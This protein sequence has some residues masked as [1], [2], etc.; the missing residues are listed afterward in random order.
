MKK[1]FFTALILGL[2]AFGCG[3]EG[4]VNP[5][6]PETPGIENT[7]PEVPGNE[8]PETPKDPEEPTDPETPVEPEPDEPV[9][10]EPD[11]PELPEEPQEAY[12]VKVAEN[13]SDWSGDYLITYTTS[14]SIKVFDSFSGSDKGVSGTDLYQK[15]TADGIH[16]SDG[17][18]YKAV[19]EKV[20]EGYSIFLTGVGYLGL[21]SSSNKIHRSDSKPGSSDRTYLWEF[22]EG[23][24]SNLFYDSRFILWNDSAS[25]FRCYTGEQ[26]ALTLYRRSISTGG[27]GGGTVTPEPEP[28]P[29]PTPDPEDPDTPVTPEPDNGGNS[30]GYLMCYDIP[31]V[32][33]SLPEGA[34]YSSK[35]KEKYG[36]TYAYIY[37]TD[38]PEQRVVTHTFSN[39][40]KIHRNYTFLY[41]YDKHCPLWLSYHMNSGYCGKGGD[42]TD[43][44]GADPAIPTDK[45]PNL[46]KSYCSGGDPYNRGHM[47][48]SH[49]RSAIR[50]ANQQ[51]FYFTNMTPQATANFNTGSG[52]WNDLEEAEMSILPSGK[53]TLYVITGCI[54]ED[55]YKTVRNQG[56]GMICAVPDQF[57]KCFMLCSFD[58]N[59]NM[60]AAKGVG[61][62]M[63]HDSPLK[64]GYKKY[65][66]TIDAIEAIAGY[67]FF[68]NVPSALQTNAESKISSIGL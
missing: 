16:S 18:A 52:C 31:Y 34:G 22:D 43:A 39:N 56:D 50:T 63:P 68:T 61:Y 21:E 36:N 2:F 40:G 9:E 53:D 48:A 32:D 66:K 60:T 8:D 29:T 67:D 4:P 28:D 64:S 26:K 47:L 37:E 17:D 14:S 65:E 46:N 15:L 62:L 6:E 20:G 11:E 23:D 38:N 57:Y 59:G 27:N 33:T 44:W 41:D 7:D 49:A 45:Q 19:V 3:P 54:F 25:C 24:I 12:Y 35:V 10:P 42:R 1:T 13:F 55:G 51:A 30:A 58:N 5:D